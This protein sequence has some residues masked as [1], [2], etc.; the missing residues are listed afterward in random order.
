MYGLRLHSIL[1]SRSCIYMYIYIYIWVFFSF[2]FEYFVVVVEKILWIRASIYTVSWIS[3]YGTWFHLFI[4]I[5]HSTH[6]HIH[7]KK[8]ILVSSV[9]IKLINVRK[10]DVSVVPLLLSAS[11]YPPARVLSAFFLFVCCKQIRMCIVLRFDVFIYYYY[12]YYLSAITLFII[13][14]LKFRWPGSAKKICYVGVRLMST[15]STIQMWRRWLFNSQI[16]SELE[17]PTSK[18]NSN[19]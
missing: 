1:I 5:A 12:E 8:K 7:I 19:R 3:F 4:T 17:E 13:Y 14:C 6:K 11:Q 16:D 15:R 2:C 9:S 18:K 10:F